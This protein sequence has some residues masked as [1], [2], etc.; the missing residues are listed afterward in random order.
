[1]GVLADK[2][3]QPQ[4]LFGSELAE[5]GYSQYLDAS[6]ELAVKALIGQPFEQTISRDIDLGATS[7]AQ[8]Q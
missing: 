7:P 8:I 4:S 3:L 5:A 2:V 6:Q 1:L